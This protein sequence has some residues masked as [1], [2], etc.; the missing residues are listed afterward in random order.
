MPNKRR[1]T[2]HQAAALAGITYRQ[3]DHWDRIRL[4]S[5]SVSPADGSGS[6]RVYSPEDVDALR[7]VGRI[8]DLG[9]SLNLIRP[10][11]ADLREHG[12]YDAAVFCDGLKAYR[13]PMSITGQMFSAGG[14]VFGVAIGGAQ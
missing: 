4:V 1:H 10:V 13:V 6:E 8:T 12:P 7:I 5:P 2:S 9:V 3:L 14:A 11:V